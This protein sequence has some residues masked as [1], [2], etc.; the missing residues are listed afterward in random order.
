[1]RHTRPAPFIQDFFLVWHQFWSRI[2]LV[3]DHIHIYYVEKKFFFF[4]SLSKYAKPNNCL[5]V[6][7][8]EENIVDVIS[9]AK[10]D[11][12]N[13]EARKLAGGE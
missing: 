7:K 13:S 12:Y 1:M 5:A 11:I 10:K 4:L 3:V 8:N 9:L 2:Q 6:S